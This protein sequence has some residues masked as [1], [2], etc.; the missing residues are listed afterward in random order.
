MALVVMDV[1]MFD[2]GHDENRNTRAVRP[3]ELG[4]FH[5][6]GIIVEGLRFAGAECA[7]CRRCILRRSSRWRR[8]QPR[9][10]G[11]SGRGRAHLKDIAPGDGIAARGWFIVRTHV[12]SWRVRWV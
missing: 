10:S 4:P 3:F 5:D 2:I 1:P 6:G 7:I 11:K 9:G 8:G 12:P